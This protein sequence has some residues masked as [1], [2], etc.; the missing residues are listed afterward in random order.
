M[1]ISWHSMINW[2]QNFFHF[3]LSTWSPSHHLICIITNYIY[4]WS[5]SW[6]AAMQLLRR[7]QD[8]WLTMQWF[9]P[10]QPTI[11]GG[12]VWRTPDPFPPRPGSC[13][14]WSEDSWSKTQVEVCGIPVGPKSGYFLFE[15]RDFI[16]SNLF[17]A[18][19]TRRCRARRTR[20]TR[21]S[22][23]WRRWRRRRRWQR[24]RRCRCRRRCRGCCRTPLL[25]LDQVDWFVIMLQS[26]FLI[27]SQVGS[28]TT[29]AMV[30]TEWTESQSSQTGG[31]TFLVPSRAAGPGKIRLQNANEFSHFLNFWRMAA[32]YTSK[33][34]CNDER[35][36]ADLG[37]LPTEQGHRM[38]DVFADLGKICSGVCRSWKSLLSLGV[39]V[40]P[41]PATDSSLRLGLQRRTF[42]QLP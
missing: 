1:A 19:S 28:H 40:A 18:K 38:P 32:T 10:C 21:P 29:S 41:V 14:P 8:S 13:R 27:Q 30:P 5:S 25:Q 3:L 23:G 24:R 34:R 20:P 2:S 26:S 36:V 4:S 35:P 22:C 9:R 7:H 42:P 37:T 6:W 39:E 31:L 33:E 16:C 15:P 12:R 11:R 17:P